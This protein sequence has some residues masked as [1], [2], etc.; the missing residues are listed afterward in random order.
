MNKTILTGNLVADPETRMTNSGKQVTTMRLAV[1]GR[2]DK[3]V[4]VDI[5]AF[6]KTAELVSKYK[7][8]GEPILVEGRLELDTWEDKTSGQKRSKLY[9]IADN[10]E[11]LS[12]GKG[13]D[14]KAESK[15]APKGS[16]TQAPREEFEESDIPF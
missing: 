11:F 4:Y 12:G 6:D 16:K 3:T 10:V 1:S 9:V 8:K 7:K 5:T 2:A 13:G 15:P 14:S